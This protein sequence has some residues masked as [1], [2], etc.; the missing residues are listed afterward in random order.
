VNVISEVVGFLDNPRLIEDSGYRDNNAEIRYGRPS[1]SAF[2][3]LEAERGRASRSFSGTLTDAFRKSPDR[4]RP[5]P[6]P[7]RLACGVQT[8][9][10]HE[11]GEAPLSAAA[12]APRAP[13]GPQGGMQSMA[14]HA[15]MPPGLALA[16]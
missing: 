1:H 12:S 4:P 6:D 8:A 13:R 14:M 11:M 3:G 7:T 16:I 10:C 9:T 2:L 15:T 5:A